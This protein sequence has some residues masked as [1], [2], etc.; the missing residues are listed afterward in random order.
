MKKKRL[1]SLL[2][3]VVMSLTMMAS[4]P[5]TIA[6]AENVYLNEGYLFM[7]NDDPYPLYQ[8]DKATNSYHQL[9]YIDTFPSEYT[10]DAYDEIYANKAEWER[11]STIRLLLT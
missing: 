6:N 7:D 2:T 5:S 1:I 9:E 11:Y 4:T 3:A 10:N 8:Y